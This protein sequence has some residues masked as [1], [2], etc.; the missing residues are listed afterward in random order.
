MKRAQ[1]WLIILWIVGFFS[2]ASYLGGCGGGGREFS[3]LVNPLNFRSL[4]YRFTWIPPI[5]T[6]FTLNDTG[7]A[8]FK[9]VEFEIVREEE[10][11]LTK[12]EL[13]GLFKV[14]NENRFWELKEFYYCKDCP[15]DAGTTTV[16]LETTFGQKT[17]SASG[18]G[19]GPGA[20]RRVVLFLKEIIQKHF[21][22]KS[23]SEPYFPGYLMKK[24]SGTQ[25]RD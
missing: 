22:P 3:P 14:L 11:Y 13:L 20:F 18:D 21:N 5:G 7:W 15:L 9:Q 10:G 24:G 23:G 19:W 6:E 1:T 8:R 16:I 2:V 4:I 25:W 17:V 12:Q